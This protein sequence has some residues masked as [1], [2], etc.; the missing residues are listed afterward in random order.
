MCC[1]LCFLTKS[2]SQFVCRK[3]KSKHDHATEG[4]RKKETVSAK[5]VLVYMNNTHSVI[6]D[7]DVPI[8]MIMFCISGCSAP[9]Q[10]WTQWVNLTPACMTCTGCPATPMVRETDSITALYDIRTQDSF[11]THSTCTGRRTCVQRLMS[12]E[13]CHGQMFSSSCSHCYRRVICE[14]ENDSCQAD[15]Q[16]THIPKPYIHWLLIF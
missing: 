9:V 13:T 11:T 10:V 1:I 15:T 6:M 8:Y 2:V 14:A 3:S 7:M 16:N 12:P 5:K 4:L